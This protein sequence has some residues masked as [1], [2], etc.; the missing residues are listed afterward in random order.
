MYL[1]L[2]IRILNQSRWN[3]ANSKFQEKMIT[4]KTQ[5]KGD[6]GYLER[7]KREG[8]IRVCLGDRILGIREG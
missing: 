6:L 8:G 4:Q 2:V 7:E 5:R 1:V 3:R